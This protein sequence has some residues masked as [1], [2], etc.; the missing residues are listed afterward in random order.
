MNA[1]CTRCFRSYTVDGLLEAVNPKRLCAVCKGTPVRTFTAEEL[2]LTMQIARAA[3]FLSAS[4]F[5]S[6]ANADVVSTNERDLEEL[7]RRLL[8]SIDQ[9][10]QKKSK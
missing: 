2:H 7:C 9:R 1:H 3:V 10:R 8:Q 6:E 5:W 4:Q